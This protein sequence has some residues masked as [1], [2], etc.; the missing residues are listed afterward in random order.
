MSRVERAIVV[1]TRNPPGA[2]FSDCATTLLAADG[3]DE[4]L[5]IDQSDV[6]E[7]AEILAVGDECVR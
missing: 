6:P 3:F 4:L 2:H 7:S 5:F 1:C